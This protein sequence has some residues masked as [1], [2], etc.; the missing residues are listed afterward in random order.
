MKPGLGIYIIFFVC[1]I[2]VVSFTVSL[3]NEFYGWVTAITGFS[4]FFIAL[5]L[6]FFVILILYFVN[7][8]NN[9][10][11]FKLE[12][13]YQTQLQTLSKRFTEVAASDT[14]NNISNP[15]AKRPI[16]ELLSKTDVP[17]SEQCLTNFYSLA[18]RFTG[19]LGPMENGYF[20]PDTA[21]QLAVKAGCRVFVLEIDYLDDCIDKSDK[22]F[23][24]IV[25]RDVQGKLIIK[26]NSNQPFCNSPEHSN[27]RE[28]CEK[29]NYYSFSNSTQN[30]TDPVIVVLYFLRQ[31]PGAYD[32]KTVLDYYSHVAKSLS[33]FKDR[34]ITNELFGGSFYR[35]KQ[36]DRLI[37]NKLS[38]YNNR[39]LIFSNANTNGFRSEKAPKYSAMDDLDYL[40]NLRLSYTQTKLGLTDNNSGSIFGILQTT[41]DYM[42]IPSDRSEEVIDN[43]KLR[44]TICLSKD[45]SQPVT[46]EVYDKI[47]NT[48]GVNCVPI[49]LFDINNNFMFTDKT[50]KTYSFM[51]KPE[52]LRYRKPGIVV[53]GKANP[54]MNS[55]QG[56]L[57]SPTIG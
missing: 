48:Y 31:P 14:S 32:S 56:S 50:F 21:V 3:K 47:T 38:D 15:T 57:R 8:S 53:P 54:S 20:D 2:L 28:V 36:E 40:I 30:S 9:N 33:P 24:Q 10:D 7:R 27:I 55:N 37:I 6:Y 1:L 49:Q 51:P 23:P 42:I 25:V 16:T 11:N 5:I 44:W 35:Q 52:P 4:L 43:T 12:S 41:D 13:A 29:I 26:Y 46:K 45:P 34:L 18:T 39:V 17:I 19:Y 22:Y